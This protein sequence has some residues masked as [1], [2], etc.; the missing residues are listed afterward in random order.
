MNSYADQFPVL[1]N[2]TYLNTASSGVLPLA[3][4]EWR[5]QHDQDFLEN[6]S[7]FREPHKDHI[8]QIRETMA[9]FVGASLDD[10]ALVPNWTF[11]FNTILE[12]V[13][14]EKSCLLLEGDYPSINWPVENHGLQCS[15]A[16]I[17]YGLEDNIREALAQKTPDIFAFSLTQYINGI[18]LSLEFLK[19]IKQLYP[20]MLL[21]ADGTQYIGTRPFDFNNSPIDILGFSGYKWLMAGY[22]VGCM[23]IKQFA[24][25]SLFPKTIGFNSASYLFG[26]NR[27]DA[28]FNK[29]LEPG[30][31]DTLN[32]GSLMRSVQ[33]LEKIG[34]VNIFEHVSSLR[35]YAIQQL[36]A[37]GFIDPKIQHRR[38]HGPILSIN[39]APGLFA[40]LRQHNIL[41]SERGDGIRISFHFYNNNKDL[42]VLFQALKDFSA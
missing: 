26:S 13:Q 38:D 21:I 4:K 39:N 40:Y 42:D 25:D 18:T 16:K 11:G 15:Y 20:E 34:L 29:L 32:F 17:D 36:I 8:E 10:V 23:F 37:L 6:A 27:E 14:E 41:C 1:S 28:P 31:H 35:T 7:V 5:T 2:Y 12:G 22:G 33:M 9:R 19:E 30:H 3:V 24:K